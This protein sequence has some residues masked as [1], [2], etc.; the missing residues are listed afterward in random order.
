LIEGAPGM[1]ALAPLRPKGPPVDPAKL[2]RELARASD[3]GTIRRVEAKIES[4][5]HAMRQSGLYS[6]AEIRPVNELRMRGRHKLG[7]ALSKI[8][9]RRGG[10]KS[11]AGIL[12]ELLAS[13]SLDKNRAQEAQRIGAMPDPVLDRA[14]AAA[15]QQ[16]ILNTFLALLEWARPYWQ[17]EARQTKHRTIVANAASLDLPP[18][19]GPFP[20]IYADPPWRFD[21]YSEKGLGN[22]PD[23]HYPTL[24]DAEIQNFKV[25]KRTIDELAHRDAALFLWCTSSNLERALSIMAAW[26]FTYKTNAVWIKDRTGMGYVFLNQHELVLYGTRGKMPA[27]LYVRSSVFVHRR[28]RHSEKPAEVRSEIERMYPDFDHRSRLELFAREQTHGWTCHGFES[29]PDSDVA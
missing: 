23:K 2:A 29:S 24:S 7:R 20:L 21:V 28:G 12:N 25:G 14:L 4:I 22:S 26:G 11:R 19:V 5:E 6:T 27:P 17:K 1:R 18:G 15:H 16:D 9:R 13:I 8:E 10:S 3:P